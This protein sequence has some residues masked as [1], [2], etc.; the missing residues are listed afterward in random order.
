MD[1]R[2]EYAEKWWNDLKPEFKIRVA[3]A[4]S[5]CMIWSFKEGLKQSEADNG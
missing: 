2:L 4:I 1:D 3:R 5:N